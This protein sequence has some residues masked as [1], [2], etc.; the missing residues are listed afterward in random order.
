M[1]PMDIEPPSAQLGPAAP[2]QDAQQRTYLPLH[3]TLRLYAGWLLSWYALV[4]ALGFYQYT[5][6]LPFRIP[7]VEGLFLSPLVR[8]FALAAFLFL[9]LSSVH[10]ATGGRKARG[11]GFAILG[12][13]VFVFYNANVG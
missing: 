7:I 4:Y 13:A 10:R 9:L 8:S 3:E 6:P 12:I 2:A 1:S 11:L 5:R